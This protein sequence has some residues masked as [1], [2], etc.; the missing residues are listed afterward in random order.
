M[1]ANWLAGA[2]ALTFFVF[3]TVRGELV[4]YAGIIGLGPNA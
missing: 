2:L 4:K 3:I 1:S